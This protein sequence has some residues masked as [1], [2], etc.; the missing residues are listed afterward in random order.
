MCCHAAR[1][2]IAVRVTLQLARF[3]LTQGAMNK[4]ITV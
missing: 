2:A 1:C 4:V 3:A